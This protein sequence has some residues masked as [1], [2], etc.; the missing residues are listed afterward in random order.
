[1]S[2]TI[3][4]VERALSLLELVVDRMDGIGVR[5]LAREAELK[6]PTAQQLLKTLQARGYLHFNTDSRRYHPGPSLAK[7]CQQIDPLATLRESIR[8]PLKEFHQ[9]LGETLIAQTMINGESQILLEYQGNHPLTVHH[10]EVVV[11]DPHIWASGSVVLAWQSADYLSRYA[12]T[13]SWSRQRQTVYEKTLANI[14]EDK[15]A[16]MIDNQGSGVAAL[17]TPV[18]D[19]QGDFVCAIGCSVPLARW[20]EE[21][22]ASMSAGLLATAQQISEQL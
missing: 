6:A 7:L 18:L 8:E 16:E 21:R 17:G 22:R 1:M 5:E 11:E 20:N 13:R 10:G 12:S 14:R 3:Q 9:A 2:N 4:S 15:L 19:R